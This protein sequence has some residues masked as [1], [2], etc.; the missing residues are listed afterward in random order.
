MNVHRARHICVSLVALLVLSGVPVSANEP[1]TTSLANRDGVSITFLAEGTVYTNFYDDAPGQGT[2]MLIL[3]R[4][5]LNPGETI[6]GSTNHPAA[7]SGSE[8]SRNAGITFVEYGTVTAV[9]SADEEHEFTSPETIHDAISL[10]NQSFDCV[11]VLQ[12]RHTVVASMGGG[13]STDAPSLRLPTMIPCDVPATDLLTMSIPDSTPKGM[14]KVFIG[15]ITFDAGATIDAFKED[16]Y[17]GIVT[18]TGALTVDPVEPPPYAYA[19]ENEHRLVEGVSYTIEADDDAGAYGLIFGFI[20]A[21]TTTRHGAPEA[22][23]TTG[24]T[25]RERREGR[26][27]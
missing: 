25:S 20:R 21:D 14:M 2:S 16:G 4:T 19:E 27:V 8:D 3:S 10:K 1:A 6:A 15:E 22:V 13:G 12:A 7:G 26:F 18:E 17:L 5:Q 24:S 23:I 11:W 9:D